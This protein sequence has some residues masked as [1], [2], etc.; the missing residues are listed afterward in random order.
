MQ[1]ACTPTTVSNTP[2]DQFSCRTWNAVNDPLF[3]WLSDKSGISPTTSIKWGGLVWCLSFLM[4]WW[5]WGGGAADAASASTVAGPAYGA[6]LAAALVIP[7]SLSWHG[8]ISGLH[9]AISLCLYDSALT[10]VELVHSA[11]LPAMAVSQGERARANA[12]SAGAAAVGSLTSFVAHST[13]DSKDLSSFRWFVVGL[14]VV[15]GAVFVLSAR[16]IEAGMGRKQL[17]HQSDGRQQHRQTQLMS[18]SSSSSSSSTAS[19][20]SASYIYEDGSC[21]GTQPVTPMVMTVAGGVVVTAVA[22]GEAGG[23]THD[24]TAASIQPCHGAGATCVDGAAAQIHARDQSSLSSGPPH[25]AS[26]GSQVAGDEALNQQQLVHDGGGGSAAQALVRRG[27][28]G[29]VHRDDDGSNDGFAVAAGT[30]D[31]KGGKHQHHQQLPPYRT[32]LAQLS[33]QPNF[34]VFACIC[35]LQVFDCTFEKN[36]FSVFMEVLAGPRSQ[37]MISGDAGGQQQPAA[38]AGGRIG[39]DGVSVGGGGNLRGGDSSSALGGGGGVSFLHQPVPASFR[40]A[41][42]SLSFL[43]PHFITIAITPLISRR[44]LHWTLS[45]VF[46][47]RLVLIVVAVVVGGTG[48][49]GGGWWSWRTL[50]STAASAGGSLDTGEHVHRSSG[51]G[52]SPWIALLFM[53]INRVASEA[54]C[55][56]TPLVTADI[57]DEDAMIHSRPVAGGGE[58]GSVAAS[59]AGSLA[60][61]SKFSQ[62]LAPMLGYWLLPGLQSHQQSLDHNGA[63]GTR[64]TPP[65][66]AGGAAGETASSSSAR[67]ASLIWLLLLLVPAVTVTAQSLLWRRYSLQGHRLKQVKAYVS[68]RGSAGP[69]H[70]PGHAAD[71]S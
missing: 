11:L 10:Y 36:F 30:S 21:D 33:S 14:A 46:Q 53:L 19:R 28:G 29:A 3:G 22:D 6:G 31:E 8:V 55:R 54:V 65:A 69:R 47:A 41:A 38:D 24:G 61:A 15:C 23:N 57:C 17:G 9:F 32:F 50:S 63:S 44:G 25:A 26:T 16:V 62:S 58:G 7:S 48:L 60:F 71:S 59:V 66:V 70:G 67:P 40:G 42:I 20:A 5:P 13:W 51:P 68:E 49:Q 18:D 56:L 37:T 2:P 4:I 43:L 39:L 34:V 64:A 12:W 27:G 45:K 1:A 52:P 35:I